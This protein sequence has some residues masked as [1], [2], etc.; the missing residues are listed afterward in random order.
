[1]SIMSTKQDLIK[2]IYF[3]VVVAFS[4]LFLC[5]GIFGFARAN[6]VRFVFT[7]VDGDSIPVTQR[8]CVFDYDLPNHI[9]DPNQPEPRRLTPEE[10]KRCKEY[11]EDYHKKETEFVKEYVYQT[12]MLNSI[13]IILIS[14]VVLAIHLVYVRPRNVLA[15]STENDTKKDSK[16]EN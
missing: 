7:K 13:L 11:Y 6:L 16:S 9:Y 5:A 10:V 15:T 14:S 8:D 12:E 4:I 1:M 2:K 3:Y